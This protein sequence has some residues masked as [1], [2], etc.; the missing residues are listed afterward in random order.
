MVE[1][2]QI[3]EKLKFKEEERVTQGEPDIHQSMT[4]VMISMGKSDN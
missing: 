1:E 3:E 2:K 4:I